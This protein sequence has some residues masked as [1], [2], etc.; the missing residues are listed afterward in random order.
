MIC[1]VLLILSFVLTYLIK[2][3][4]IKNAILEEVNER[5]SHTVPTPHGGGIAIAITWF[6]GLVYLY[7]NNEIDSNLFYAL[8]VGLGISVVSFVDDMVDLKPKIRIIMHF[9]FSGIGLWFL[10]GLE[11]IDFWLFSIKNDYFISSVIG[12][13]AIVYFINVANFMDGLNGFLGSEMLFIGIAGFILFGDNHFM[14]LSVA[15]LGFLYWNFGNNAKIFMGDSGSTLL[16]YNVA[17]FTIY[18]SN[19]DSVNL[20]IWLILF[21]LFWFDATMTIIRRKLNGEQITQAH[22]KHGY[23]RLHQNGW[24][25]LQVCLFGMGINVVLFM[26]VYFI[27]NIAIAFLGSLI[28]LY[29]VMKF[30]DSKKKFDL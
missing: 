10:G 12:V 30:V 24:S 21:G 15:I 7:I 11:I 14:V 28:V 19:V 3:Y 20:W 2:N 29:G 5:S 8:F 25:H 13:V 26:I 4:Y 1:V 16:G 9:L 17:I 23:Q 18:Y 6:V 27:S 22:K